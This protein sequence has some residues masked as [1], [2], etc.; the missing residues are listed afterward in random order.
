[1][2]NCFVAFII[3]TLA[4]QSQ[5]A[6]WRYTW[7][8]VPGDPTPKVV[9]SPFMYGKSW[10]YAV[11]IDDGPASTL[12]VSQPLLARYGW[13]DAPPGVR[14]GSN[15]PF[16]G[17]AAVVVGSIGRNSTVLSYEQLDELKKHGWSIVNHSYWHSGVHW[18][19]SK[20]NT[21]EQFRRELF[22][23]QSILAEFVGNG[24]ATTHLVFPNGDY[25]YGPYLHEFGLRSGSRTSGSSPRNLF[26]PKLN[27]LNFSRNYLDTEP[28]QEKNDA[29]HGLP[30]KPKSGDFIID[31]THGMNADP[32]SVNNKLW[33]ERL[34][35][36][37]KSWGPEGDNSMWVAPT[38]EVFDY[39][40]AAREAKATATAGSLA[41]NIPD[42]MP[43]TPL[44]IKI[45]G[46]GDK[47]NLKAPAGGTL[48][49]Q[50]DTAWLT[51]PVIGEPGTPAPAPRIRRIYAGEVKNLAWDKPVAIA[52]VRFLH[53]GR[54]A[55]GPVTVNILKP[56][57]QTETIVSLDKAALEKTWGRVL[58]PIV[59]D[60]A[61]IPAKELQVTPDKSLKEME[62]WAVAN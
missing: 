47:T 56:D 38:D 2:N 49:R 36:I 15:K 54:H 24:R 50:G 42:G 62:V 55:Q 29:L 57:G 25:N 33:V 4:T 46:L 23:S 30:E 7:T 58:N 21:P 39:F 35:H 14:G 37:A 8:P 28:W 48:Y 17:A 41:V 51:T 40:L 1:M 52:G 32:E 34:N 53:E 26:D 20:M 9:V 22:W 12:T 43:G 27:L 44:T 5:A 11:E 3:L 13:N 60:R 10:A 31:F 59:P 19:K 61:A 6:E 16:V 18:D 45:T